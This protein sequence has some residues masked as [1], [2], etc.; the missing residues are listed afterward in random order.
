M[1]NDDVIIIL[2]M[3]RKI[4]KAFSTIKAKPKKIGP[5]YSYDHSS[6]CILLIYLLIFET[7]QP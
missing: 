7:G 3:G 1:A 2:K 4:R 6:L 5:A